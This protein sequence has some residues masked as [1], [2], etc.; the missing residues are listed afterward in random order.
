MPARDQLVRCRI[1]DDRGAVGEGPCHTRGLDGRGDPAGAGRERAAQW[2]AVGRVLVVGAH[3][4]ARRRARGNGDPRR[5]PSSV[6]GR[7]RNDRRHRPGGCRVRPDPPAP[8][9][10]RGHAARRC[11]RA[12]ARRPAGPD[13]AGLAMRDRPHG[14]RLGRMVLAMSGRRAGLLALTVGLIATALLHGRI[15]APPVYDGIAVPPEPYRWEPPPPNVA[16]G[17]KPPLSGEATLPVL[18][19]QVAGGGVQTG[20]NQVVIYFGA[21]AFKAPVAATSVKCTI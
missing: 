9:R 21:G 3:R 5:A 2:T 13:R 11:R 10:T 20:D 16:A 15:A 14:G 1:D 18:N 4:R 17:N 7:I 6:G 8:V 19:G 12:R